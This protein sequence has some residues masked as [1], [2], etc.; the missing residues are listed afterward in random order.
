[1]KV[2]HLI[3]LIV[4]LS[5][6]SCK[7]EKPVKKE[8]P[9]EKK[10]AADTRT[11]LKIGDQNFSNQDLKDYLN[12]QYSN[13]I[14]SKDNSRLLSILFR[15]FIDRQIILFR[16]ESKGIAASEDE[17][18]SYLQ[19]IKQEGSE[20]SIPAQLKNMVMIQKFLMLEVYK[21]LEVN[22]RDAE[23]YYQN[24]KTE[25]RKNEEIYLHQIMVKDKAKAIR[26]SSELLNAPQRF[27]EIARRDSES[28]EK[29]MDGKMGYFEKGQLPQEMENVVFSL[30]IGQI[31][32]VV[33]TPF[34]FYIFKI[35][36]R[37][38]AKQMNFLQV[39]DNIK[40]KLLSEK[41]SA[42]YEA[43]LEKL[44]QEIPISI[45]PENLYFTYQNSNQNGEINE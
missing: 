42:A 18:K 23:L 30:K 4:L 17:I 36:Q 45:Y 31:S 7:K 44:K 22:D 41:M 13:I 40:E 43:C 6:V 33:E 39:K 12:L 26:I 20:S 27:E 15:Q 10:P 19:Q 28:P 25:F 32:P 38:S 2:L 16:A 35:T 14:E 11:I 9:I 3:F 34:G 29:E 8:A 37:H 1:M 24:H 5:L 21:D